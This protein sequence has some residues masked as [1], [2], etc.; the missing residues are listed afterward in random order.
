MRHLLDTHRLRHE[1]KLCGVIL[2]PSCKPGTLSKARLESEA[3]GFGEVG[4]LHHVSQTAISS[5]ALHCNSVAKKP[6]G[7][8]CSVT[9]NATKAEN[10]SNSDPHLVR[11]LVDASVT[12]AISASAVGPVQSP[13]SAL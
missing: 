11:S 1:G 7:R 13:I 10:F 6:A 3:D 9:R 12:A 5:F 2:H 8:R 4:E